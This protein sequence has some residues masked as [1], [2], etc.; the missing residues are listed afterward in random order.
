[1]YRPKVI[2]SAAGLLCMLSIFAVTDLSA[3]A[4]V[5]NVPLNY[6]TIAAAVQNARAG[7]QVVIAAGIYHEST[8][9][10]NKAIT[11]TSRWKQSQQQADIDQTVIDA[12]DKVLFN[13]NVA[14]VEISGLTIINGNHPL[15]V[16][17][18]ARIIHNHLINNLDAV[19]L[20]GESGGYVGYNMIEND[21]DDGIDIDIG[22]DAKTGKGT[23]IVIEYN[24]ILNSHDDGIEI[25]LFSRP[26]QNTNYDIGNNQ[27]IGSGNAG[28]QLISYDVPT[29]KIFNIHHNLLRNCK[30]AVGCMEGGR[31]VENLQGTAKMDEQVYLYNNTITNNQVAATGGNHMV[32]INNV[33]YQNTLGGFK[34]FGK[35]S[36]IVNNLF[37]ENHGDDLID[38]APVTL[39]L[40]PYSSMNLSDLNARM[41]QGRQLSPKAVYA[42]AGKDLVV[43]HASLKLTGQ[44]IGE[45]VS[46][47]GKKSGSAGQWKQTGGPAE[48]T[49]LAAGSIVETVRFPK[50]G[51]YEF[52]FAASAE[53]LASRDKIT[54]RYVSKTKGQE[55]F[56]NGSKES[57]FGPGEYQYAY[58]DVKEISGHDQSVK[59]NS[60]RQSSVLLQTD[61]SLEYSIGIAKTNEYFIWIRAKTRNMASR[62]SF[63]YDN[64]KIGEL[65]VSGSAY[66]W[67]KLS[68]G[69]K[70]SPGQWSLLLQAFSGSAEVNDILFTQDKYLKP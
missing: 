43:S 17:A 53:P 46:G 56:F 14:G 2:A 13:I 24:T 30:I 3:A 16:K 47:A 23:D 64:R 38:C 63:T 10:V 31:T 45:D 25:R 12:D 1:M 18:S 40:A 11:I 22:D 69:I 27:I 36:A 35:R 66:Q 39:I 20:E 34:H 58:G 8:I 29:G 60:D 49:P 7:D 61:A 59:K 68:A 65:T 15:E 28:I 26:N 42:F 51:I 44:V 32:A 6:P 48:V 5:L 4:R 70:T 54:I 37:S 50:P 21:R 57:S 41:G 55:H 19:S 33:V 62:L 9:D 52:M 67:Y